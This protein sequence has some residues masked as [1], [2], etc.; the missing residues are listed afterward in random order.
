MKLTDAL[1]HYLSQ[2]NPEAQKDAALAV[3]AS[4]RE[5]GVPAWFWYDPE[6]NEPLVLVV[7]LP[8]GAIL[9]PLAVLHERPEGVIA[10]WPEQLALIARILASRNLS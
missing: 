8:L 1:I 7:D 10:D 3:G 2:D 6:A 9:L 5:S 4:A